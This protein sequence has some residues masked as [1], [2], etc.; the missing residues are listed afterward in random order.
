[1]IRDVHSTPEL[2]VVRGSLLILYQAGSACVKEGVSRYLEERGV[3]VEMREGND[4]EEGEGRLGPLIK[5]IARI[6]VPVKDR[7]KAC[8][9]A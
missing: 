8:N 6:I 4:E 9:W 7:M 3:G 5:C 1:M 2:R